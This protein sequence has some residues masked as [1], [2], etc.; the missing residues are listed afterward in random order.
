VLYANVILDLQSVQERHHCM[1]LITCFLIR[2]VGARIN[3][4]LCRML[5][6]SADSCEHTLF[7][8]NFWFNLSVSC[9]DWEIQL[10]QLSA[11]VENYFTLHP[12]RITLHYSIYRNTILNMIDFGG[13]CEILRS[14][15]HKTFCNSVNS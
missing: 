12:L 15:L 2:F 6:S 4:V 9:F 3:S 8:S 13:F 14:V 11:G 7:Y 1:S 10:I 5:S